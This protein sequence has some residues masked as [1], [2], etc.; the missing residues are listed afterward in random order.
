M[1]KIPVLLVAALVAALLILPGAPV[2][3]D[4]KV[5]ICHKPGTPAQRTMQVP[6]SAVDGHLAHG[7]Q[8][9]ACSDEQPSE[10]EVPKK[11]AEKVTICHKPGTEAEGTLNVSVAAL[12]AHLA[13]GDYA[14]P[15]SG[16]SPE[17]A[18][19]PGTAAEK[20]TLC[21]KPGT[22]AERTMQVPTEAVPAHLAHGD[23][24]GECDDRP[25]EVFKHWFRPH[26][27]PSPR[28]C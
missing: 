24:I 7:D 3:A 12:E 18:Q 8:P 9:G 28:A 19:V 6:T 13:H 14:G 25:I 5:T 11:A 10:P 23:Y 16:E 20:I 2:R 1:S 27:G 21:H 26:A 15:C 22:P 17:E 4:D